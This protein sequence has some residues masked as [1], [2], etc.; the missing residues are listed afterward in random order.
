MAR[1]LDNTN[2]EER[3]Q[4]LFAELYTQVSTDITQKHIAKQREPIIVSLKPFFEPNPLNFIFFYDHESKAD[5][6]MLT[7]R[8]YTESE[9]DELMSR[10]WPEGGTKQFICPAVPVAFAKFTR[11]K[12]LNTENPLA[13]N[14]EYIIDFYTQEELSKLTNA[15]ENY[16]IVNYAKKADYQNQLLALKGTN[17]FEALRNL[18]QN[19]NY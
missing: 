10:L 9:W 4:K 14:F 12:T 13:S 11:L 17:N 5:L 15:I 8:M 2:Q 6:K 18:Q 19:I 3:M 1:K 7:P 16:E